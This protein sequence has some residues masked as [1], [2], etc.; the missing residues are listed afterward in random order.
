MKRHWTNEE[1]AEHWTLSSKELDLIGDSKTDH[2]LL[3]AACLLKYFQY[4]GCFPAQKQDVP[5]IVIVHLAQQ[6]GV[7]PEKIIPYDWEGRTIK[8]HRAAIRTFLE[9]HEATVQDEEAVVEWL[10]QQM[11]V[12]QRQED[13]LIA[14]VYS[15]CKEG[16]IEPPTP[17]RVR[18]L[19]HTAI[20]RFDERLCASILQR[21]SAETRTHLDALLTVM[22]P[23]AE[24]RHKPLSTVQDAHASE[25]REGVPLESSP[26]RP[27]SALHYLKEDTGPVGLE[28]VM[29]EIA[30]LERIHQ[31]GLPA[32]LFAQVSAKTLASYRQRIAVE[33]L[34]E[35]RRHPDRRLWIPWSSCSW[36]SCI[37]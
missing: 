15:H 17:D 11:L 37:T 23:D 22:I 26:P 2:N 29:L 8:A 25:E 4:E 32:D 36:T 5:P 27:Q 33:E 28:R 20:H 16:R 14:S 21:L 35:V 6:L 12:E 9:V 10:C 1:L 30:K 3:G 13:A 34:Q 24:E 7:V 19:V 18:R 31:L